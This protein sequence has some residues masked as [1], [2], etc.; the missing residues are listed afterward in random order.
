MWAKFRGSSNNWAIPFVG[1][2]LANMVGRKQDRRGE[3]DRHDTGAVSLSTAGT[4]WAPPKLRRTDDLLGVVPPETFRTTMDQ[5]DSPHE[6]ATTR[7]IRSRNFRIPPVLRQNLAF[8]SCTKL[9][10]DGP[11]YRS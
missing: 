5:D 8:H 1:S 11:G 4:D 6:T 10:A 9:R 7:R 2:T 3:D